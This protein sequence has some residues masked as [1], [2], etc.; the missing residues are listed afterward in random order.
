MGWIRNDPSFHFLKIKVMTLLQL[1]PVLSLFLTLFYPEPLPQANQTSQKRTIK[2][3]IEKSSTLKVSGKSNVNEF[4]CE[5]PG[6]Y[7]TDTISLTDDENGKEVTLNG[8][9]EI[10]IFKF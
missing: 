7:E 6:Y 1:A 8:C 9:L 3:A 4:S 10:D 2:W 5:V